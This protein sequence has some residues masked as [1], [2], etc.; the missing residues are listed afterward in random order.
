MLSLLLACAVEPPVVSPSTAPG[1]LNDGGGASA[2]AIA[3][4]PGAALLEAPAEP[5]ALPALD[6][7]TGEVGPVRMAGADAALA[8][9]TT[10]NTLTQPLG[11]GVEAV[12]TRGGGES[13]ATLTDG[14][15]DCALLGRPLRADETGYTVTPI[16]WDGI[17]LATGPTNPVDGLTTEQVK[18][19]YAGTITRW[20]E[21]GGADAAVRLYQRPTGKNAARLFTEHFGITGSPATGVTTLDTD[22]EIA[23]A[24][25]LDGAGLGYLSLVSLRAKGTE[26]AKVLT[27]DGVA[28]LPAELAARRYGLAQEV[29]V[30]TRGEPTGPTRTLIDLLT[31]AEGQAVV[32]QVFVPR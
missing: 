21:V 6:K 7:L 24:L 19:L 17:V 27:L 14:R 20:Q 5:P 2:A 25:K 4:A 9:A 11:L 1:A 22:A 3:S 15:A 23:A 10:V 16:G 26:G 18:G 8:L 30:V 31:S 12:R 32:A 28:P 13:L 29:S